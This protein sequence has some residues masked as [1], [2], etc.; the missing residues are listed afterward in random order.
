[1]KKKKL[2]GVFCCQL[3]ISQTVFDMNEWHNLNSCNITYMLHEITTS[4]VHFGIKITN[5]EET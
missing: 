1:M 4:V 2:A 5:K 3:D